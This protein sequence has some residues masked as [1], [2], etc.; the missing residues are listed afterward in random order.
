MSKL[1]ISS[2]KMVDFGK[3]ICLNMRNICRKCLKLNISTMFL[4]Y[5]LHSFFD[6]YKNYVLAKSN[7]DIYFST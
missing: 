4:T 5:I 3:N 7:L 6:R 1:N 2:M